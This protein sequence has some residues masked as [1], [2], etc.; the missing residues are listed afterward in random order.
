MITPTVEFRCPVCAKERIH[1]IVRYDG[2]E[3][4]YDNWP[5]F[6]CITCGCATLSIY[7]KDEAEALLQSA[8][9]A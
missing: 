2:N 1:Y 5:E 8:E 6:R 3:P 4:Y 9:A 7:S